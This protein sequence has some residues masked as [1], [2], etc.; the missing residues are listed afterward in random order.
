MDCLN[1]HS[2]SFELRY[3]HVIVTSLTVVS[4]NNC[5]VSCSLPRKK[6]VRSVLKI[7]F[8]QDLRVYWPAHL[9]VVEFC[10][11]LGSCH[12]LLLLISHALLDQGLAITLILLKALQDGPHFFYILVS[13]WPQSV[14]LH[15]MRVLLDER[16]GLLSILDTLMPQ[17]LVQRCVAYL[18]RNRL[19]RGN[20]LV[21]NADLNCL[22]NCLLLVVSEHQVLL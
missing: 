21:C 16:F 18:R 11:H 17:V 22:L 14:S 19:G 13:F 9:L 1:W 12:D 6:V 4:Q 7:N 20:R 10:L 15:L 2:L 3:I 8:L 5:G